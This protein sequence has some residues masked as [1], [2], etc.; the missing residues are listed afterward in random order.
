MKFWVN[1][2]WKPACEGPMHLILD[3]HKAQKTAD[4]KAL[5]GDNCDTDITYVPGA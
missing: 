1:Q 5:L 2:C 4:V 3:V